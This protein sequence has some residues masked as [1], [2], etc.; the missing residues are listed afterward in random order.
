MVWV[1]TKPDRGGWWWHRWNE[2]DKDPSVYHI[3]L[4]PV[5]NTLEVYD[6]GWEDMEGYDGEWSSEPIEPLK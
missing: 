5:L 4:N 3:E 1:K 2:Q 6:D